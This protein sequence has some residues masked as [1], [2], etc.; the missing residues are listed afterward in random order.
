MAEIGIIRKEHHGNSFEILQCSPM[1]SNVD[2]LELPV[3]HLEFGQESANGRAI[4]S[5]HLLSKQLGARLHCLRC[6]H[7]VVKAIFRL[8]LNPRYVEIMAH[9]KC[10]F[11]EVME[12]FVVKKTPKAHMHGACPSVHCLH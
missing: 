11:R 6:R 12:V 4:T 8:P 10:S 5:S 7:E 1:I 3:R 2:F 9:F